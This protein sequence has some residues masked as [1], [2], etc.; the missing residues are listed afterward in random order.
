MKIERW[1]IIASRSKDDSVTYKEGPEGTWVKHSD[2]I[3]MM[4]AFA[5]KMNR[6]LYEKMTPSDLYSGAIR[7]EIDRILSELT[8]SS[9]EEE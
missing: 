8:G 4:E 1:E 2:H 7:R 6:L 5:E 9:E 3:A